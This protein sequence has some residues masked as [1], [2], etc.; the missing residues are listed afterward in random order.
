METMLFLDD[1]REYKDVYKYYKGYCI[2]VRDFKQ[3]A[4]YILTNDLPDYISFDHDLGCDK[5]GMDCL[6]WLIEYCLDNNKSLP[7]CFS[8]S[9]NSVG[10]EN[11]LKKIASFNKSFSG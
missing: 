2:T 3:F 7:R 10:R 11:I 6:N 8:H 9:M 5:S 4:N 1:E